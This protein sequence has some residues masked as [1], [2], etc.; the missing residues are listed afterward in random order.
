MQGHQ[1]FQEE[2]LKT[3]G[4]QLSGAKSHQPSLMAQW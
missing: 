3:P 2:A 4:E 1:A